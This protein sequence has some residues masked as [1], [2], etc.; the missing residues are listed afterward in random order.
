MES[1][2][3]YGRRGAKADLRPSV[4]GDVPCQCL[5]GGRNAPLASAPALPQP[6]SAEAEPVLPPSRVVVQYRGGDDADADRLVAALAK[7]D[8]RFDHAET[9]QVSSTTRNPTIR[10]FYREDVGAA[11][12]LKAALD[13]VGGTWQVSNYTRNGNKPRR[14]TLEVWLP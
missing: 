9:H 4:G 2:R 11:W 6:M 12:S 14:G 8:A 1:R 13:G 5:C 3:V 7:A 10:F